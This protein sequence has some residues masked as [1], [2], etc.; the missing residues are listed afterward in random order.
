MRSSELNLQGTDDRM[1]HTPN[2]PCL[3]LAT[4]VGAVKLTSFKTVLTFLL[5]RAWILLYCC[6]D[7]SRI[8]S[9]LEQAILSGH[10]AKRSKSTGTSKDSHYVAYSLSHQENS[11]N[12]YISDLVVDVLITSLLSPTLKGLPCYTWTWVSSAFLNVTSLTLKC[13]PSIPNLCT[14]IKVPLG[15]FHLWAIA[16]CLTNNDSI[17]V[18]S[19]FNLWASRSSEPSSHACKIQVGNLHCCL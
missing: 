12:C 15:G 16:Q 6:F 17:L 7:K 4:C 2:V 10:I 3:Q 11:G 13:T 9:C 19:S 8:S 5:S 18:C 1:A 14:Y